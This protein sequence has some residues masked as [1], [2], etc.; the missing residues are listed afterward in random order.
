M[1]SVNILL[2]S[3]K[4]ESDIN[5]LMSVLNKYYSGLNYIVNIIIISHIDRKPQ[6]VSDNVNLHYVVKYHAYDVTVLEHILRVYSIS[7]VHIIDHITS[8][9]LSMLHHTCMCMNIQ[10]TDTSKIDDRYYILSHMLR[11][12]ISKLN[13]NK[14]IN[15]HTK[16]GNLCQFIT[17]HFNSN[18][19]EYHE[20]VVSSDSVRINIHDEINDDNI[21]CTVDIID[22]TIHMYN[23]AYDRDISYLD[24]CDEDT[25]L[26]H[27]L[28]I[29]FYSHFDSNSHMIGEYIE[30]IS[31]DTCDDKIFT[32]SPNAVY[33]I[34][35]NMLCEGKQYYNRNLLLSVWN[36]LRYEGK[37]VDELIHILKNV[38]L[39]DVWNVYIGNDK[40]CKIEDYYA[41]CIMIANVMDSDICIDAY[42][43]SV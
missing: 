6:V 23:Y 42:L 16:V 36:E 25:I 7:R 2:I 1:Q 4:N 34:E 33:N 15:K 18:S 21:I 11:R 22:D 19:F 5:S 37:T 17:K 29:D 8:S 20:H 30:W 12:F 24:V 32:I 39:D 3:R 10:I 26:R 40:Y 43:D 35:N 28:E 14:N 9:M 13:K 41:A 27:M 38:S 31:Y